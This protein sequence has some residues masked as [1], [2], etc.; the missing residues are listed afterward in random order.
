MPGLIRFSTASTAFSE[1]RNASRS[2]ASSFSL[3][4]M[5]IW[6]R[7]SSARTI[8]P[9][10]HRGADAFVHRHRRDREADD[11]QPP[12]ALAARDF[13]EHAGEGVQRLAGV[14]RLRR[15]AIL[16]DLADLRDLAPHL[17][18]GQALRA[19]EQHRL[20]LD[21]DEHGRGLKGRPVVGKVADELRLGLA[22]EGQQ[23]VQPAAGELAL[24]AADAVLEF[25]GWDFGDH[26]VTPCC[27]RLNPNHGDTGEH[28]SLSILRRSFRLHACRRFSQRLAW[29]QIVV[30][31]SNRGSPTPGS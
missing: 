19:D 3:L 31:T 9:P 20:A 17:G 12:H 27:D 14:L 25:A 21:R 4:T 18:V 26:D 6:I 29:R 1:M 8:S 10:G 7:M 23:R 13:V 15:L 24:H 11:P 22:A 28:G 5:R 2:S 30:S 16:Q